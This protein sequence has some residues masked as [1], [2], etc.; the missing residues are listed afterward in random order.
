M[1]AVDFE[2]FHDKIF[3]LKGVDEYQTVY[4]GEECQAISFKLDKTTYIVFENPEDGYRSSCSEVYIEKERKIVN[5]FNGVKVK[6]VYVDTG[7]NM[8]VDLVDLKTGEV[9][10]CFGTLEYNDYYPCFTGYFN[11][12][13]MS[14]NK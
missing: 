13:A 4:G 3:N 1:C 14:V 12:L 7:S 5:T 6:G 9:V 2:Y 8:Y 11:P 10:V